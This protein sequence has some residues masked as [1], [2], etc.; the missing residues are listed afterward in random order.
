M[1]KQFKEVFFADNPWQTAICI[2]FFLIPVVCFVSAAASVILLITTTGNFTLGLNSN[3]VLLVAFLLALCGTGASLLR[4]YFEKKFNL[5][6]DVLVAKETLITL[7]LSFFILSSFIEFLIPLAVAILNGGLQSFLITKFKH[8]KDLEFIDICLS[9]LSAL[10]FTTM[11]MQFRYY[12]DMIL[13]QAAMAGAGTYLVVQ[14]T[15]CIWDV[16]DAVDSWELNIHLAKK[17]LGTLKEEKNPM[18][19]HTIFLTDE[20]GKEEEFEY[21]DRISFNNNEYVYLFSYPDPK[22]AEL[23]IMLA[24]PL[25]DENETLTTVENQALIEQLFE[26]FKDKN[27]EFSFE[28]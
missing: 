22:S 8:I 15:R 21:I 28:D 17:F 18:G 19:E 24:T 4:N 5:R 14:T 23:V 20:T 7:S 6:M 16:V 12:P 9:F 25:D 26:I 10:G 11:A 13:I 27:P 2:L 1:N 3:Q